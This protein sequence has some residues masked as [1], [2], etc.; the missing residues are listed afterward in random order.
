LYINGQHQGSFVIEKNAMEE[1]DR[2]MKGV[3][4]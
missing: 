1:R 2:L 3:G 4:A